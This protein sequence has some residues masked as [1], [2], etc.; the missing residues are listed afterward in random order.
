[1]KNIIQLGENFIFTIMIFVSAI[2]ANATE[3]DTNGLTP[4]HLAAG[5]G[6]LKKIKQLLKNKEDLFS[7][8]SKMG[9]S[10]LHKAVYSGNPDVVEELLKAGALIDLQSPSN[11]DTPLHDA[12]YFK[13]GDD[14]R[15][16]Q[17]LLKYRPT[18]AIQ[19]RAGLTPLESARVLKDNEVTYLLEDYQKSLS[20]DA[21]RKLM[22]AVQDNQPAEVASMLRE[23]NVKL[24]EVDDQGFT[25]LIWAAR[26]GYVEIVRLLL[27]KGANPNKLDR[28]MKANAGHKAAYWGR[29]DVMSL[30]VDHGL[31]LDAQGG[32]NGYTALHDAT[33]RGHVE[34]AKILINHGA[35]IDVLGQDGKTALDLAKSSGNAKLLELFKKK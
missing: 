1:M 17:I 23:K 13:S 28:W 2:S 19:N 3:R 32:Y 24:D 30:L 4:L 35:R 18:L 14:L 31:D 25:P 5:R 7:V 34:V 22:K 6:D 21:G 26:E 12:I 29:A 16:I 8:D 33:A 20:T 15:V 27:D 9:V 10:I 11:G